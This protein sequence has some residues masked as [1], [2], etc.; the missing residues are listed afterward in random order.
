[1][2]RITNKGKE[3]ESM[4]HHSVHNTPMGRSAPFVSMNEARRRDCPTA[5]GAAAREGLKRQN[6]PVNHHSNL[7]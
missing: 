5:L 2:H 6:T 1:M 3:I 4:L 7:S